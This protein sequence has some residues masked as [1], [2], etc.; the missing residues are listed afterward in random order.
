M[1]SVRVDK[2]SILTSMFHK[3]HVA[4]LMSS[5]IFRDTNRLMQSQ[6]GDGNTGALQ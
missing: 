4:G 2:L 5:G 6:N 1:S 3:Y